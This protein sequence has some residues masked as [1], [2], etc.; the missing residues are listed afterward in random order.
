MAKNTGIVPIFRFKEDPIYTLILNTLNKKP[1]N[2]DHFSL[3]KRIKLSDYTK[4]PVPAENMDT[5]AVRSKE[6]MNEVGFAYG[7]LQEKN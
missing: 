4:N 5:V 6:Y 7:R 1:V 3:V 2:S